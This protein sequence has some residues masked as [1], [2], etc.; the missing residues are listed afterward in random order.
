MSS[1]ILWA[2]GAGV[3]AMIGWSII[4]AI[5]IFLLTLLTGIFGALTAA[6][7]T[8]PAPPMPT[9]AI[10]HSAPPIS[11]GEKLIL[12]QLGKVDRR[13]DDLATRVRNLETARPAPDPTAPPPCNGLRQ[14]RM[15]ELPHH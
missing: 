2:F 15:L 8:L 12:E 11:G 3:V 4:K 7:S 1:K 6:V 5:L 9:P 10:S 14:G 13:V